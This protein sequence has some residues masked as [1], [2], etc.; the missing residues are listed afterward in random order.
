MTKVSD[1][2]NQLKEELEQRNQKIQEVLETYR[3][4]S[5]RIKRLY[6]KEIAEEKQRE[7]VE[8]SRVKI[9]EAHEV[10]QE[11]AEHLKN[12]LSSLLGEYLGKA[13]NEALMKQLRMVREFGLCLTESELRVFA[14]GMHGNML[15][16]RCVQAVAKT[17]GYQMKFPTVE[18]MEKDVESLTQMFQNSSWAPAGFVSEALEVLPNVVYRGVDQ[19]RPSVIGITVAQ[20]TATSALKKLDE[21]AKRWAGVGSGDST[22]TLE[23]ISHHVVESEKE[24]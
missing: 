21:A 5:E 13:S 24:A 16:L 1:I 18:D 7:I 20:A 11:R 2:F 9:A 15:G 3:Q 22:Y 4:E 10:A 6:Q 12:Q 23:P 17:S 19:G 14:D 8:Q